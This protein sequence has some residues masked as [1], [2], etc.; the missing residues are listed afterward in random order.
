MRRLAILG[1]LVPLA[2]SVIGTAPAQAAVPRTF[3]W[4]N[5]WAA[6]PW[7]A[8]GATGQQ[9]MDA[10]VGLIKRERPAAGVLAELM[11]SQWH[12]FERDA[13]GR[14]RLVVGSHRGLT[15]G[16]F[17][18]SS[19]Y[20]QV[21]VRHFRSYYFG[22]QRVSE[23]VVVLED[24]ATAARV[25]VLAVHNPAD[26]FGRSNARW[27][28]RALRAEAAEVRRL[29][30]SG[31]PV[32][33]A[34][35]FNTGEAARRYLQAHGIHAASAGHGAGIDQLFADPSVTFDGYRPIRG[36]QVARTTNHRV[37]YTARYLVPSPP[38]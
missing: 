33:M 32:L 8:G 25:A 17:Y 23:P 36:G 11:P 35:D 27:R 21:S 9:R 10:M 26:L 15:N 22:G 14:Y 7:G 37:V 30:A 28:D 19:L 4:A 12:R 13:H 2:A 5:A 34:G 38:A 20:R 29:R 24:R 6:Y 31:L 1:L 18:D 3:F 16:V